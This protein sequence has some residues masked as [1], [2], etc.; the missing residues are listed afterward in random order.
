MPCL[1]S[2]HIYEQTF[3]KLEVILLLRFIKYFGLDWISQKKLSI[4]TPYPIFNFLQIVFGGGPW[5]GGG[6]WGKDIF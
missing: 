6:G 3:G 1:S 2:L 5:E 4:I